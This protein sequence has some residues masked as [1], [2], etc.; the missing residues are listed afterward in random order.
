MNNFET[1]PYLTDDAGLPQTFWRGETS[2]IHYQQFDLSKTDYA[3]GFFFAE[4]KEQADQYAGRGTHARPFHLCA[5]NT[6]D[7]IDVYSPQ[8]MEFIQDY[9]AKFESWIDRETGEDED[10]FMLFQ[11]GYLYD[12]EGDSSEERWN[13]VFKLAKEMGYDAVRVL[14][15]TAGLTAPVCVVFNPE[16]VIHLD[17]PMEQ[18]PQ[19]KRC[20][21]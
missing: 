21:F 11:C 5:R 13:Y 7:L 18:V 17:A 14:D 15:A 9:A 16:Q 8:A 2:G 1:A 6:L 19:R 20:S 10:V 12:Y 3:V 4:E